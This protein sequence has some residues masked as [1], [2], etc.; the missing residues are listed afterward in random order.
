MHWTE[1]SEKPPLLLTKTENQR[2]NWRKPLNSAK[3]QNR[4]TAVFKWKKKN[5]TQNQESAKSA[6]TLKIPIARNLIDKQTRMEKIIKDIT[7]TT[8]LKRDVNLSR[9]GAFY[10]PLALEYRNDKQSCK[11]GAALKWKRAVIPRVGEL[12][13]LTWKYILPR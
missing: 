4:K 9:A 7:Q 5:E 11:C 13:I 2:L 6:V 8:K 10:D 1:K 3:H 12:V